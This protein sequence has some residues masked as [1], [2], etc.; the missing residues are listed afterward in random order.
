MQAHIFHKT[1][2]DLQTVPHWH[3][4][5]IIVSNFA[6]SFFGKLKI[7]KNMVLG[8]SPL[9]AQDLSQKVRRLREEF[10]KTQ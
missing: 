6:Q 9:N 3:M 7:L 5:I 1:G 10:E 2:K 4:H 8:S